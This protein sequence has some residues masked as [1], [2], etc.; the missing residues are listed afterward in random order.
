M[1]SRFRHAALIALLACAPVTAGPLERLTGEARISGRV[2][3]PAD[4]TLT[5]ELLDLARPD[6]RAERLARLTLPTRGRQ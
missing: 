3:L 5:L 2:A 4:A 6:A 1:A